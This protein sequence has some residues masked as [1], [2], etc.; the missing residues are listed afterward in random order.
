[1]SFKPLNMYKEWSK[2]LA[3]W[4]LDYTEFFFFYGL[5]IDKM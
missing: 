3:V 2:S 1:M 5:Q 4:T